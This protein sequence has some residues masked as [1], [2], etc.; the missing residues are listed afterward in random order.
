MGKFDHKDSLEDNFSIEQLKNKVNKF[1]N[2]ENVSL[3]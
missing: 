1:L 2:Y 3:P